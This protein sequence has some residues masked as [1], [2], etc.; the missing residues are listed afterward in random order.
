M[1]KYNNRFALILAARTGNLSDVEDLLEVCTDVNIADSSSM[2]ALMWAASNGHTPVAKKLIRAAGARLDTTSRYGE[3]ALMLATKSVGGEAI[4]QDL[5]NFR[6]DLNIVSQKGDTALILA[7][8]LGQT[9][10]A[11]ALIEAG[12]DLDII[13]EDDDAALSIAD[14]KGYTEIAAEIR[15]RKDMEKLANLTAEL[16]I[17]GAS[18]DNQVDDYIIW[19]VLSSSYNNISD[20]PDI[21]TTED[22]TP[23]SRL[24]SGA[25]PSSRY[26]PA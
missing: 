3:T 1:L 21:T 8:I 24:D 6:A 25:G 2:T 16:S 22:N 26:Q 23:E 14:N 19:P 20:A 13:N 11:L 4:V 15:A 18:A 12:A 5:I 17:E 10:I 9:K 7:L